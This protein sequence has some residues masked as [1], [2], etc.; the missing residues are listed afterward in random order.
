M[1]YLKQLAIILAFSWASELL[2]A[3]IPLPVPA[4]IYGMVLLLGAFAG[5][6]LK[7]E[8][9]KEA[10]S[11]LVSLL[12]LLFVVP[13]VGLL[14]CWDLIRENLVPIGVIII[15]STVVT[16]GVAGTVTKLCQ[17]GGDKHD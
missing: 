17:K 10:G 1:K 3:W 16:F 14:G 9:V 15:L 8:D 12:P 7:V 6:V 11:F 5:N 13:A 4:A 2:H